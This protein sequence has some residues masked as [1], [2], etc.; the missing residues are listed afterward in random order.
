VSKLE[1]ATAHSTDDKSVIPSCSRIPR[2]GKT[3]L[4]GISPVSSSVTQ[5]NKK[6]KDVMLEWHK[7]TIWLGN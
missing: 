4:I 1:T 7:Q 3:S 2:H 6:Y 5:T